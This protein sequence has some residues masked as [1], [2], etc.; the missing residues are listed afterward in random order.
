MNAVEKRVLETAEVIGKHIIKVDHFLNH[1]MDVKFLEEIANLFYDAFKDVEVDKILTCEASGIGIAVVMAQK[2]GVDLV[3][4]KKRPVDDRPLHHFSSSVFS[5]TKQQTTTFVVSERFL[6]NNENI[7]II[8][9]FLAN[10]EAIRG[11]IDICQQANVHIS[12]IGMVVE[13]GFQ[14]G[15]QWLR[16]RG[17]NLKSLCIIKDVLEGKIILDSYKE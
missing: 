3:F 14:P 2:F 8:D 10:G 9:D 17:Y 7:L 12:G 16:E 13:K 15:G 4:A 11:L 5:Y 6:T 1:Y